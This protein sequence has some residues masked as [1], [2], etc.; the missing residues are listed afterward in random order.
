M[1]VINNKAKEYAVVE[2]EASE[3]CA[4]TI[5]SWPM[6]VILATAVY[7]A[8]PDVVVGTTVE[9]TLSAIRGSEEERLQ[10]RWVLWNK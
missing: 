8:V 3:L 7:T 6:I 1:V 5:P 9:V 10:T 4:W 2:E